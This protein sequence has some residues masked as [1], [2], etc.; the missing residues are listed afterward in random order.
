MGGVYDPKTGQVVWEMHVPLEEQLVFYRARPPRCLQGLRCKPI[1]ALAWQ[2]DGHGEP[3]NAIFAIACPCGSDL[4]AVTTQTVEGE[5]SSISLWCNGCEAEHVVFDPD[6]HGYD[7]EAAGRPRRSTNE[8]LVG[9]EL[10]AEGIDSP[11]RVIVRFEFP[12]DMLGGDEE[13]MGREQNAFSWITI[14]ACEAAG[15]GLGLL[16]EEECA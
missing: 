5:V 16:F 13:W 11:H 4:F 12:S 8:D 2:F 6:Q 1:E 3:A 14:L 15:E 9:T 10:V 7:A